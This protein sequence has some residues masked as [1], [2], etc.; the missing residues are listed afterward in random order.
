MDKIKNS[1]DPNFY[2]KN[3]YQVNFEVDGPE[4]KVEKVLCQ[5]CGRTTENGI[6]C[7]GI[8]VEDNEY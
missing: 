3:N 5:H 8:C 1:F 2:I 4:N 7:L 6:R